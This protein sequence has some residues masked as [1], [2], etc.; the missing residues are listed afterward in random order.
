MHVPPK[1]LP[2][3]L[4]TS[5][6]AF[7]AAL[8]PQPADTRKTPFNTKSISPQQQISEQSDNGQAGVKQPKRA[9]HLRVG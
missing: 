7:R 6:W 2:M 8:A 3:D 9:R 5:A 4:A 1:V